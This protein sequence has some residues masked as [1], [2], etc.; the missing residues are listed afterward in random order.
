MLTNIYLLEIKRLIALNGTVF[1][2][3]LV[4]TSFRGLDLD[5]NTDNHS[6]EA[7]STMRAFAGAGC[8]GNV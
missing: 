2:I 8:S 7:S 4:I 5:P 6:T 1:G 3:H